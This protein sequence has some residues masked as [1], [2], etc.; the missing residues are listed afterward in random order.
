M[1]ATPVYRPFLE[2]ADLGKRRLLDI[3]FVWKNERW[4]FD[5]VE[6]E[7]Q[8]VPVTKVF[9]LCNPHNPLGRVFTKEELQQLADFCVKHELVLCSDEIHCDLILDDSIEH[10][11][12]ASLNK[13]VEN[14]SITLM[15]PSKTFNIA[16]LGCSFAVIP[17]QQLRQNFQRTI[18]G[19]VP[20]PSA[21]AFESALAAYRDSADWHE[22]VVKY[23][24]ANHDY[25]L[26]EV[27]AI[28][29]LEMKPMDATYLAWID[30]SAIDNTDFINHL[31]KNGLGVMEADIFGGKNAFRLNFATQRSVLEEV[32][33][34]LKKAV[35]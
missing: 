34:R 19:I 31:L 2:V 23:L 16:G 13:D 30:Y 14:Q 25:L 32:V 33:E 15:A 10:I 6:M 29:G 11:S 5:F 9:M 27:N 24:K 28:V 26:K 22:Q 17:N 21:F 12:V 3:P 18:Y 20:H 7:K 35:S 8:I 1:T 4:E